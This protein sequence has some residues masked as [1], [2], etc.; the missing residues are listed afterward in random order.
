VHPN[1]EN[2]AKGTLPAPAESRM[3][4]ASYNIQYGFGADGRYDLERVARVVADADI[5]ALQEVE[6]FWK[7][8]GG[9][10]QPEILSRLLPDHHWVYGPAFDM[11]A[12]FRVPGGRLVNRRRQFGT[13]LMSRLPIAWSRL[14]LLPMQRTLKPLNTQNAALECLIRT[15]AGPVRFLSIHLA[16]IGAGERL[17]QIEFLLEKHR[18]AC[19]EGGPWSGDDDEPERDWTNGEAEPECPA[20]AVWMGDFNSEPGSAEYLR[21]AGDNPYHPGAAYVAG[22]ADAAVLADPDPAGLFSHVKDLGG[23]SSRRRLDYCFVGA[24][25]AA[26][27]RSHRIDTNEPASDHFPVFVDID[28]AKADVVAEA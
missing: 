18:R 8:T 7:R 1:S 9:D 6:R 13:M 2:G 15:P 23:R 4:L 21:V 10:D 14:H 27:V 20:A 12:S 5:I 3:K 24:P 22:F 26:R 19:L 25:L 11:D 28:L 16:H 17:S